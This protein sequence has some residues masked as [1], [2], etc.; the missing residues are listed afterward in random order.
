MNESMLSRASQP[1]QNIGKIDSRA[2]H[3]PLN[4][5]SCRDVLST[6]RA[7]TLDMFSESKLTDV[8]VERVTQPGW[9]QFV[10]GKITATRNLYQTLGIITMLCCVF[11]K[12]EFFFPTTSN[13]F[14]GKEEK[15]CNRSIFT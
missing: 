8:N 2:K 6:S 15:N 10:S 12:T 11:G 14:R 5:L 7:Y 4:S 3:F 9:G 1:Q 13:A